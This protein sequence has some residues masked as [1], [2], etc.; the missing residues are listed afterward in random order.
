MFARLS[1]IYTREANQITNNLVDLIQPV[2]M[3]GMGLMV[4]LLFASVLI[5]IYRLTAS[6]Q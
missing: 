3:I 6:F 4:G 5:P 1:G 2:L